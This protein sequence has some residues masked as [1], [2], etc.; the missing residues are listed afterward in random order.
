MERIHGTATITLNIKYIADLIASQCSREEVE[1]VIAHLL[2]K[3]SEASA[4]TPGYWELSA[5]VIAA[6]LAHEDWGSGTNA[7]VAILREAELTGLDLSAL[8][9]ALAIDDIRANR[10]MD[11]LRYI[12]DLVPDKAWEVLTEEY[13]YKP[14]IESGT[15]VM[16]MSI[17]N[18]QRILRIAMQE[19][20][21]KGAEDCSGWDDVK[22]IADTQVERLLPATFPAWFDEPKIRRGGPDFEWGK[23]YVLYRPETPWPSGE[24]YLKPGSN[25]GMVTLV[26]GPDPS[27]SVLGNPGTSHPDL[28]KDILATWPNAYWEEA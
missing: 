16:T 2:D 13:G 24:V 20:Y 17:T 15:D 11:Y 1:A 23:R 6:A 22:D 5:E 25:A 14:E 27:Q 18:F 9:W 21:A 26:W 10:R 4:P 12:L 28:A 19:G 3:H 8:T 7:T